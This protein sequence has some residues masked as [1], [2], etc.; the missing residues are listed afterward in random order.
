MA[1]ARA[2]VGGAAR[3]FESLIN[4]LPS[5][6]IPNGL[7]PAPT[8]RLTDIKWRGEGYDP[9]SQEGGWPTQQ[10]DNMQEKKV[11]R[12]RAD[13]EYFRH[14]HLDY[15]NLAVIIG[16]NTNDKEWQDRRSAMKQEVSILNGKLAGEKSFLVQTLT[17]EIMLHNVRVVA[18]NHYRQG[19]LLE[20]PP[21]GNESEAAR[22]RRETLAR[23]HIAKAER[24]MA[25]LEAWISEP[26]ESERNVLAQ[27]SNNPEVHVANRKEAEIRLRWAMGWEGDYLRNLCA[28]FDPANDLPGKGIAIAVMSVEMRKNWSREIFSDKD[29]IFSV[30]AAFELCSHF[31]VCLEKGKARTVIVT[32]LIVLCEKVWRHIISPMLRSRFIATLDNPVVRVSMVIPVETR[33][34]FSVIGALDKTA[35][36]PKKGFG[37]VEIMKVPLDAQYG[38]RRLRD[39]GEEDEVFQHEDI[40]FPGDH[41]DEEGR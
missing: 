7:P 21:A 15:L 5:A 28:K 36:F 17:A 22:Q 41:S 8:K 38:G 26:V 4:R 23:A 39:V 33:R 13:L 2:C 18:H 27:I 9:F 19:R 16:P 24:T 3:A 29:Q 32:R 14:G 11:V 30:Y 10:P 20:I 25:E 12:R 37:R 35:G 34:V 31:A 1:A 6:S 40:D